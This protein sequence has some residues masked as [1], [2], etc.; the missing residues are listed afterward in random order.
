M[1]LQIVAYA[2]DIGGNLCPVGKPHPGHLPQRRI[3]LFGGYSHNPGTDPPLLGAGLKRRRLRFG[4]RLLPPETN[5]LIN[6]WHPLKTPLFCAAAAFSGSK[7]PE[8]K[9]RKTHYYNHPMDREVKT[10]K[11]KKKSQAVLIYFM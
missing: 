1:F 8:T 11:K 9:F 4:G 3:G 5:Q 6:C 2:G 10:I 7:K